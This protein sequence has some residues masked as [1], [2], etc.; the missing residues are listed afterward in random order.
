MLLF[1]SNDL[2]APE[3]QFFFKFIYVC[4]LNLNHN[5]GHSCWKS[6]YSE[7]HLIKILGH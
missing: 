3:G 7:D 2:K 6:T 1:I 5:N 4:G